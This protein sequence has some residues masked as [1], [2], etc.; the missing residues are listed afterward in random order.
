MI[1]SVNAPML[2]IDSLSKAFGG[3]RVLTG[4]SFSLMQGESVILTGA[5]GAGKT[6]LFNIISGFL[7]PDAG[8]VE[9]TGK[10]LPLGV[11]HLIAQMG[12][13]RTFQDV[14]VFPGMSVLD[15][16][17]AGGTGGKETLLAGL[18]PSRRCARR[19]ENLRRSALQSLGL[20]SLL[21]RLDDLASDLS[22][23][24]QKLLEIAR[25]LT[26]GADI[27]L[28]DEPVAGVH[29]DV[30]QTI[31]EVLQKLKDEGKTMLIIEHEKDL[32][33]GLADREVELIDG[34]LTKADEEAAT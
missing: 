17:I 2:R 15:N 5:N 24:Q 12:I 25:T 8:M 32:L 16:A 6:T 21:D 34:Q 26:D 18:F 33:S 31:V 20:V 7:L 14:K 11:P 4:V 13:R 3:T 10:R 23:G 22:F 27:L 30:A 28:L 1:S 29:N 9:A 19:E